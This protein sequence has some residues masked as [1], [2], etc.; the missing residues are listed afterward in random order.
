MLQ[1]T[2]AN[3]FE[4]LRDA[5]LDGV[6]NAPA[7]P[8][9]AEQIIVPSSAL[10]RH[11]AL[12]MTDRFGIC[13]NVEFAFLAQ[14]LWC[15]IAK[16][17]PSVAA[18]SPFASP[19]LAW[20]IFRI[21]DDSAFVRRFP[22]L[23]SYLD[24]ADPVVRLDLSTRV[25]VL[26]EQYM[27][28][29]PACLAE[30]AE[31]RP[32][33]MANANVATTTAEDI[34]WQAELWRRITTELGT[35]RE[36][37]AARFLCMVEAIGVD[38]PNRFGLPETAHVFCLPTMPPLY[39]DLL[40]QLGRW[41]DLH[42]YVLNPCREYWFEI[43]DR[44]RLGY[45]AVKGEAGYHESGNS[46][47]AAWGKQTQS[48][49]ELLLE[50]TQDA[51]IDDGGFVEAPSGTMLAQVQNAILN[52]VEILPGAIH[53]AP[54]DRSIEIH[55]CHS[56]TRE[57]EVLQDQLLAL[58]AGPHPPLASDI[59]VVTPDLE[60]AAP[61]VDAVFG[62]VASDRYIPFSVSGRARSTINGPAR[63]LLSLLALVASRFPAS[64]VFDLLQQPIVRRRVG[65]SSDDLES[66]RRY[67]EDSGMRWGIDGRHRGEYNLPAF[68]RY[69]FDDGMQRLFLGYALPGGSTN[70]W[71]EW[72]PAGN[73]EGSAAAVLGLFAR[74]IND[75]TRLRATLTEPRPPSDWMQSLHGII[76]AFFA[77]DD[78]DIDDL[79][80]LR[81]AIRNLHDNMARG[82]ITS[83][84]PLEVVRTALEALLDDPAR[85]GV[86]TG[87]VTFSAIG[88]LRNLPFPIVCVIGLNDG[89]FPTTA[90]PLEFDLMALNP[91]RGDRQRRVDE[92]NL[93][94][95]LILAARERLYLSYTGRSIRD[96]APLPGSVLVTELIDVLVPAIATIAAD[97]IS[98]QSRTDALR[99]IVIEHPLQPFSAKYFASDADPRIRSFNGELCEALRHKMQ[100]ASQVPSMAS[101]KSAT[102]SN[103][104]QD[105]DAASDEMGSDD[106][107][108]DNGAGHF[109]S[110]PLTAPGQEWREVR[111]DILIRF[112]RNPCRFLLRDRLG[113]ELA[114]SATELS[115]EEPFLPDFAGRQVLAERLLPQLRD[116]IND[117]ELRRL[118]LAGIEY[119]PGIFGELALDRELQ[120]LQD[121]ARSV[122]AAT[123]APCFPPIHDTLDFDLA[124]EAWRL[125]AAFSDLRASGL[126]R[127]RYDDTRAADYLAGWLSHLFLCAS[128]PAGVDLET[129]WLSRDG[130]Y[131]L[132]PCNEAREILTSLMNHYRRG[133]GEPLHFFPKTAWKFIAGDRNF[134]KAEAA[135]RATP[136]R[137]W[138]EEKDPA[139]RL[140]LRGS[141]NPL[142][143]DFVDCA[144]AVFGTMLPYLEDPRLE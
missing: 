57:L 110:A 18:E 10:R 14:W 97:A 73:A 39:I 51:I 61:L 46:L 71:H 77:P 104:G 87:T 113:I 4:T 80:E 119:P 75:L 12:A 116:G 142:D 84:I 23:A 107:R 74:F 49:I 101:S 127:Q 44:K 126:V 32:T 136:D 22:R 53:P 83:P 50:N 90:R 81:D 1:I 143:A 43:V 58:F 129:H 117:K 52:L 34:A 45:L 134:A 131:R 124:G 9:V 24:R 106:G 37:P 128:R 47:L 70:P 121:F 112:F 93:F 132:H 114:E 105:A 92:R 41:V 55:V 59:L 7:S 82:G 118:A 13:A 108:A 96:N 91:Q 56:L 20:R 36:H 98:A 72:L 8:F 88:S 109:F 69:S 60:A 85:G 62:N 64:A 28:Y 31:G 54:N 67:I 76:E 6:A 100:A 115:D 144:E 120:T 42:L 137:P 30:W 27:T 79:G 123:A 48:H 95:D 139:V 38:A 33:A 26:L 21:F 103:E 102:Q 133:L 25:A 5:L 140:A 135:W 65:V 111:L 17:V 15:Q 66:I 29:R 16:V 141:G 11:L 125:T 40:R 138:G 86:A 63:A 78:E 130:W 99:R 19:V 122:T 35:E 3:R 94:L 68:D 89:A 2:F